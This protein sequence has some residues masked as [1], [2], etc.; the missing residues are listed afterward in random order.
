M[1]LYR[2]VDPT[3]PH[4]ATISRH[5]SDRSGLIAVLRKIAICDEYA[6]LLP[7]LPADI[8]LNFV[9]SRK[10]ET[11][12]FVYLLKSGDHYKIGR[13]DQLERRVKE[14][15]IALPE[16]LVLVHSIWTD[17]APGIEAYW[18]RRFADRRANGEWFLGLA[19]LTRLFLSSC[20]TPWHRVAFHRLPRQGDVFHLVSSRA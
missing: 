17:D 12:G 11:G 16:S 18:H 9:C 15:R 1:Q 13:S 5:F 20:Q 6:D 3:F 2:N 14:V 19:T 7:L 4:V 10:P 8:S